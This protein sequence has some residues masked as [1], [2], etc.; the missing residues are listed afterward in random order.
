MPVIPETN[1]E[2]TISDPQQIIKT[3]PKMLSV[4]NLLHTTDETP[5]S[6]DG[7]Y[8]SV[9]RAL[10]GQKC[11]VHVYWCF[12]ETNR[13]YKYDHCTLITCECRLASSVMGAWSAFCMP[14]T[15]LHH[16]QQGPSRLAMTL[17]RCGDFC[18][19]PLG[20]TL[21]QCWHAVWFELN[22][23]VR[24]SSK[25]WSIFSE[26]MLEHRITPCN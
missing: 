12:R 3:C 14:L 7:M 25:N 17:N 23:E 4:Y 11:S 24:R 22:F 9:Y 20:S 18:L 19:L 2:I 13:T 5:R 21:G 15:F 26:R 6:W 10:L 8:T 1:C 16:Y